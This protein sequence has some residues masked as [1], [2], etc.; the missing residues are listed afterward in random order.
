MEGGGGG[1]RDYSISCGCGTEYS[2]VFHDHYDDGII[3]MLE[4]WKRTM[5]SLLAIIIVL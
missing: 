5:N 1:G 2:R 3:H 4:K